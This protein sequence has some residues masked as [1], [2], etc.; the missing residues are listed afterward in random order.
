[1][2]DR[3]RSKLESK[4]DQR[5]IH[6]WLVV[7][8]RG[9]LPALKQL[10]VKE[11]PLLDA[12][13]QGPYWEGNFRA[14]H[15]AVS[16]GHRSV[17][18]WLLA[19]G[20]SA[21]PVGGEADWAPLH[22]AALP[23]KRDLVRLLLNHGAEMDI[24]SA[25]ALGRV[26]VVRR[27]LRDDPRLVASRGPDGAT[28][29]HFAGSPGVAKVLLAAGADPAERDRFHDQ[30]AMEWVIERPNV[31]AVLAKAG[32]NVDIHLACAMGDVDWVRAFIRSNPDA[33]HA[34]VDGARKT[35]AGEGE[36]PLTVAARYGQGKTVEFLLAQGALAKSAPSPLPGAVHKG[37]RTLVRRLLRAGA[38]PNTMGPHGHAALHAAAVYGNTAM[39]RLLLSHGARL[40]L[41]DAEH[42][43][44][45]LDWALYHRHERAAGL[46]RKRASRSRLPKKTNG[47]RRK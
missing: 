41:K 32:A 13:G 24:F 36:T 7:A 30:T 1:M 10:F 11:P 2:T 47:K 6:E 19:K 26:D 16:R 23:A 27:M 4:I 5:A 40:D 21:K 14:L 44:T 43:G 42:H 22:F 25:A 31:A 20:S 38:D 39:I 37:D 29:L 17:V 12:L 34:R 3:R 35:I 18:R 46:L 45:P 15:Y 9:D 33:V 28:P 8:E